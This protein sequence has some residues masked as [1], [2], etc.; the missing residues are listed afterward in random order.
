MLM[1]TN[2]K[3]AVNQDVGTFSSVLREQCENDGANLSDLIGTADS[4]GY[5]IYPALSSTAMPYPFDGAQRLI[6]RSVNP[7]SVSQIN[8]DDWSSY[9]G[10]SS[11]P[12]R[13]VGWSGYSFA[14]MLQPTNCGGA[15]FI[16]TWGDPGNQKVAGG[17]FNATYGKDFVNSVSGADI[18]PP[19][20]FW[21][22]DQGDTDSELLVQVYTHARWLGL[23]ANSTNDVLDGQLYL[24]IFLHEM[25]PDPNN[26]GR[27]VK[28]NVIN[29]WLFR[30][31][32][33]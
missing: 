33:G 28:A 26:Q 3:S 11:N 8:S 10:V 13:Q 9:T 12:S 24:N 22:P 29:F 27:M 4:T 7:L 17:G 6:F 31:S 19:V 15:W 14:Y 20:Y 16:N 25:I 30:K 21:A 2:A 32:C 1:A 18:G 23:Y 5:Y